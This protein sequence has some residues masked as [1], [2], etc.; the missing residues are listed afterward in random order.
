MDVLETLSAV[1]GKSLIRQIDSPDTE[2]RFSMLQT[3][4]E[5]ALERL[6][7]SGE[8][9]ASR[10]R[11]VASYVALVPRADRE[12][13]GAA[14]A[15]NDPKQLIWIPSLE[16]EP[17]HLRA[18]LHWCVEHGEAAR[19]L[20]DVSAAHAYHC[21]ALRLRGDLGA[22]AGVANSLDGFAALAA[23]REPERAL[24]LAAAADKLREACGS[25]LSARERGHVDRLLDPALSALS[26]EEA[27]VARADGEAMT[28]EQAAALALEE[29]P[30][31]SSG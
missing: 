18:A 8:M 2:P 1:V 29:T 25:P 12:S 5:Y 7:V 30:A 20:G 14:Q 21:E 26:A 28:Q 27:A 22:K 3:I 4:Q 23:E 31:T 15:L 17:D 16:A 19:E 10:R 11:H 24:R 9:E 6:A 13:R